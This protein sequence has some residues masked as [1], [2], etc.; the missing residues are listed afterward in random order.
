[1]CYHLKQPKSHNVNPTLSG[2]LCSN[3][4]IRNNSLKPRWVQLTPNGL[5]LIKKF[6]HSGPDKVGLTL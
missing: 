2:P 1:M 6:E 5:F 3:F 4:V